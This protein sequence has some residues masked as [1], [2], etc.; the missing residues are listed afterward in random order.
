MTEHADT[1]LSPSQQGPQVLL[2]QEASKV[3]HVMEL[4][5]LVQHCT[6]TPYD[7]AYTH[8]SSW[9]KVFQLQAWVAL[10]IYED[11]QRQRLLACITYKQYLVYMSC[12][13]RS[14]TR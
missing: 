9:N 13:I 1:I 5:S 3:M 6:M 11:K 8:G 10:Y 2:S 4:C 14:E 12:I 7:T